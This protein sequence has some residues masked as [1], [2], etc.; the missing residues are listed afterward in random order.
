MDSVTKVIMD[1]YST[2]KGYYIF[3]FLE[4]FYDKILF[5]SLQFDNAGS[6]FFLYYNS[7]N[8]AKNLPKIENILTDW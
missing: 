6:Q 5:D 7:N 8:W 2:M 4:K 3:S 1:S